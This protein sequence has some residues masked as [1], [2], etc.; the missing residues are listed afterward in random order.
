MKD[1]NLW[2]K[3]I[4]IAATY[5]GTVV[6]AGFASG[7]EI[8]TF[9]TAYG[10]WGT[11]GIGLATLLFI[12]LGYQMMVISHRLG[13]KSYES[14]NNRLFGPY[15]GRAINL[16]VFFT[17]LGVT[18][19]ML[20][21]SGSVLQEQ[22]G[23][24]YLAG[25]LLTILLSLVVLYKGLDR[26]LV[27]NS[28]VVPMM[29]LFSVLIFFT[30]EQKSPLP[31]QPPTSY[32]FIW[33]AV[34]Y[35]SF[36]LAMAQAVLIPLGPYMK[37][38]RIIRRSAL[39]GGLGLGFMLIIAHSSMLSNWNEVRMAE[40]PMVTI[41]NQWGPWLQLFFVLVLYLEI[42]TT[43]ISNVFGI[44]QQLHE[45]FGLD[46]KWIHLLLFTVSVSFCLVGYTNLLMVLYPL[47][48]Y[49]G[50]AIFLRVTMQP[51]RLYR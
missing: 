21:G 32:E 18:T 45:V 51:R 35:V 39:L 9:F 3:S 20:A 22:F 46:E 13:T 50:L 43:L 14:F 38:V 17:L 10:A 1:L 7:Q 8:L 4:P 16:I 36:N 30:I 49:L 34:L 26:L 40:V 27:V 37:D 12:Y 42:F 5:I 41:I 24:P 6:G 15:I 29:L 25:I 44:T 33:R 2:G 19:V 23:L 11:V 47:F 31:V 48:G 28:I